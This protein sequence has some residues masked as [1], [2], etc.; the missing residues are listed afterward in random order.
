MLISFFNYSQTDQQNISLK[1]RHCISFGLLH[2]GGSLLGADVE[3]LFSE[4]FSFQLGAGLVGY[5]CGLNYHRKP[6]IRSSFLSLQY[7][8]QGID[9]SFTQNLIGLNYVY[10][11]KK[12]FTGQ[13]GLGKT[14]KKGPLWP[15]NIEFQKIVLMYSLGVYIPYK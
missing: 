11:G 6:S 10:R 12:W 15:D 8:N 1:N 3:F 14:I 2:G 7:W 13:L 9:N 5:G 4:R